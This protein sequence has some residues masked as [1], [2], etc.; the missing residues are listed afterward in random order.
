MNSVSDFAERGRLLHC[1]RCHSSSWNT[2]TSCAN[3]EDPCCDSPECGSSYGPKADELICAKCTKKMALE[4]QDEI[5]TAFAE[6][7]NLCAVEAIC[8]ASFVGQ[9]STLLE[10]HLAECAACV[11]MI[12]V[13]KPSGIEVVSIPE[14]NQKE[15]A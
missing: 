2:F 13:L 10:R 8:S 6:T 12:P 3:C 14:W 1:P 4:K 11:A 7:L 9:M 15:V 5:A